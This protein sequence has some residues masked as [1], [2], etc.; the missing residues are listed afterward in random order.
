MYQEAERVQWDE[1][2]THDLH[3][4]IKTLVCW[5]LPVTPARE[6]IGHSG[7]ALPGQ[8]QGLV[9]T[10]DPTVHRTAESV[11]LQL[12]SS[13]GWC[14][15]LRGVNVSCAFQRGQPREGGDP[16]FFEPP[17]RDLAGIETEAL[18]EIAKGVFGLPDSPRGWWKE[19]RDTLQGDSW[20]SLKLDPAFF[21]LR[22]F[23]GHLIGK[24]I[25]HVDDMLLATNNS[26]QAESHIS[27]LLSKY[28]IKDDDG[29]VL[30]CGKRVRTVP[31]DMKLGGLSLQQDEA[32]CELASMPRPEPD[33]RV[34]GVQQARF[35]RC[36]V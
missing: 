24:I 26:H 31:D 20:T 25:V 30:Y 27:R 22:D 11:F 6:T 12:V 9:R 18:I 28:D 17:S 15:S 23:S 4:E 34:P 5:I 21:C 16:L 35:E 2:V 13:M 19:L 3:I 7:S 8:A 33:K 14:R 1:W 32:R 29:G 10:D 36:E